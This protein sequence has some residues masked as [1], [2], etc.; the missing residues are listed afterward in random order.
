MK[1]TSGHDLASARQR[2]A[3]QGAAGAFSEEAVRAQFGEE[4]APVPSRSFEAVGRTILDG[5]AEYGLLPV[6]NSLAGTV[7]GSLDV[8]STMDLEVVGEVVLLIRHFLMA[9]PGSSV[10][11]LRTVQSHP[12]ALAQCEEFF[13]RHPA[14]EAVA[15]YDTA[16]AA[17]EVAEAGDRTVA[18]IAPRG[19]A[20]MYGLEILLEDLQ[21]RPD[22]QTRFLVVRARGTGGVPLSADAPGKA[23]IL[24]ETRNA[25]GGLVS[26]LA[27]LAARGMNLAK[28][29][30]RPAEVPW[31][32]R[33]YAE[34]TFSG[35]SEALDATLEE[36]RPLTTR[37][38]LLGSFPPFGG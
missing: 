12:V 19:A 35:G 5:E 10:D 34:I 11:R 32:Y 4:C 37:L 18:A 25:P 24:F 28:L 38:S 7:V 8:L 16:G 21:D 31:S 29:D 22:N 3:F 33:F 36:I 14:L 23:A 20:K 15:S 2:V 27:P 9:L 13:R 6:E 1:T 17:R 26:V 30:C